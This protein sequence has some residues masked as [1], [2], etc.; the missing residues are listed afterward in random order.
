MQY[1]SIHR[2]VW[3]DNALPLLH[4]PLW[5]SWKKP[6]GTQLG[7]SPNIK[8]KRW[9]F[10]AGKETPVRSK[11]VSNCTAALPCKSTVELLD[12]LVFIP[13]SEVLNRGLDFF[14]AS[15]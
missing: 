1:S 11:L 5:H 7:N 3:H 15:L 6:F 2:S 8:A 13:K 9:G 10:L 12:Q 14:L 4:L